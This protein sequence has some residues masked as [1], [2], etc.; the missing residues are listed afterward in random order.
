VIGLLRRLLDRRPVPPHEPD[1]RASRSVSRYAEAV[2]RAYREL[3]NDPPPEIYR[4]IE[5]AEQVL[6]RGPN[7][8]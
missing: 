1:E 2:K 4:E 6:R 7:G 3:P 5:R 8:G